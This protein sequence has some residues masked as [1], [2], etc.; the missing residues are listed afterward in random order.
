[1]KTNELYIVT[2]PE[3]RGPVEERFAAILAAY[4]R[5]EELHGKR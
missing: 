2:H 4:D 5:A 3:T 1:M